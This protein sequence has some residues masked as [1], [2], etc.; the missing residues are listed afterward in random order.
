MAG[1][2][3]APSKLSSGAAPAAFTL[4]RRCRH[5]ITRGVLRLLGQDCQTP[6]LVR[7]ELLFHRLTR[8][9]HLSFGVDANSPTLLFG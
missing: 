9:L 6:F 1:S 4:Q 5:G 2:R 7:S 3:S 8:P